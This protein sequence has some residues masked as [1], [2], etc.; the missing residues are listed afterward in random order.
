M[1]PAA[2]WSF[3]L[4]VS[5]G[6]HAAA[7][8]LYLVTRDLDRPPR[9]STS[10]TRLQLETVTAPRQEAV[11][12]SPDGDNLG[13]SRAEGQALASGAVPQS[14]AEP[15]MDAGTPLSAI[16]AEA[17]TTKPVSGGQPLAADIT[18]G[19]P[20][21]PTPVIGNAL[22]PIDTESAPVTA[23]LTNNQTVAAAPPQS[24]RIAPA[25]ADLDTAKA[26][27]PNRP[28]LAAAAPDT[29]RLKA[30]NAAATTM[31]SATPET[32][33]LQTSP[34]AAARLDAAPSPAST[35]SA[36]RPEIETTGTVAT[37][38][39]QL[40]AAAPV[41]VTAPPAP[42]SGTAAAE[43]PL[44][45]ANAKAVT[46][47]QFADRIVTDPTAISTIQA[48]MAPSETDA[49]AV[50]DD[51]SAL[52]SGID[53]ARVSATFL[54]ETGA[55]EMRGHIPDPALRE[56]IVN[57]MQTQVGEGLPV[58]ANLLHLPAPQCGALT[59]IA[60]VGLPQS[61]DQFTNERLVG[62]TAHARAYTYAEGQR[63][64]FDLAAPD[65]DAFVYVD[66]FNADGDVIHLIPNETLA[67]ENLPAKSLFGVGTDRPGKPG[68]KI[69]IGPPF[70]Q[71]IAV[72]FAAS[73]PLY[74]GLRPI[75][76]PAEPYLD[77]L[78]ERVAAAREANPDFKGEWVYFF[79]TTEPATQ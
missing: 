52:L 31:P 58:T 32:V 12:R 61:T 24:S 20:V 73:E 50:R 22:V 64:Q 26:I 3:A 38:G 47:W 59:G 10:E 79:I 6:L 76:E 40:A 16:P 70:G 2:T 30:S 15:V 7:A 8:G 37:P 54:P 69:T 57:A 29:S 56:Q 66:Y 14:N 9:Q 25:V 44:P 75:V 72:A 11:P 60:D 46:G 21:A 67:L 55:L 53:C 35:I 43:Q 5:A 23:T 33:A 34:S 13:A 74:D 49:E 39:T 78:K 63:L 27:D 65:Y 48:F 28:L 62:E 19:R 17:E 4:A 1:R 51:L 45:A 41:G 68:L 42:V 18:S 36:A 77:F 71:E